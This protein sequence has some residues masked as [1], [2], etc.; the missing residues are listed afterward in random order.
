VH[1]GEVKGSV[2]FEQA[3]VRDKGLAFGEAE[4][5]PFA[6]VWL[7]DLFCPVG[8]H[9]LLASISTALGSIQRCKEE[10]EAVRTIPCAAL[11]AGHSW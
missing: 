5:G 7:G 8:C 4:I 6:E 10:E 2:S 1:V 3:R 9:C 11:Y